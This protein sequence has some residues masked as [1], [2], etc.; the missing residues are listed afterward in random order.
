MYVLGGKKQHKK[1]YVE[2]NS[3]LGTFS[4]MWP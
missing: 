2:K 1:P 3:M 4:D